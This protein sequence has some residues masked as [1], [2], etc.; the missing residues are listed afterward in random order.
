VI[1][2]FSLIEARPERIAG[3]A[4]ELADIDGVYEVYSVAGDVDIVAVIR[5]KD[6]DQLAETVTGP[7]AHLDG[8]VRTRTLLAFRAY[9]QRDIAAAFG[10]SS[11]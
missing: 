9:G 2:A 6:H 4:A 10:F 5:V 7:M 8:I 3:L 11:D 1:T